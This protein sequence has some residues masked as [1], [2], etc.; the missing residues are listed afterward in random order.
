MSVLV[1]RAQRGKKGGSTAKEPKV[2]CPNG[3]GFVQRANGGR[4]RGGSSLVTGKKKSSDVLRN[5]TGGGVLRR[6]GEKG[7]GKG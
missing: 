4:G 1:R 6:G 5:G 3:P 2:P 7:M